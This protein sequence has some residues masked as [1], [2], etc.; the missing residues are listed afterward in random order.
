M[1]HFIDYVQETTT[2]YSKKLDKKGIKIYNDVLNRLTKRI[3]EH[4]FGLTHDISGL[5]EAEDIPDYDRDWAINVDVNYEEIA[6][7]TARKLTDILFRDY[8][9]KK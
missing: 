1:K 4:G 9:P 2:N 5:S 7:D 8:K 3:Y 6:K